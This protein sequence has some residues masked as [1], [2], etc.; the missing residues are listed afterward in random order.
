MKREVQDAP[1]GLPPKLRDKVAIVGFADGHRDA[2][3]ADT[4]EFE[5]WGLNR[6]F[7]VMK[8]P[9][10]AWFDIHDLG[11]TYGDG[12]P[13]GRDEQWIEFARGFAGPVY[14]RG[15]DVGLAQSWG[16]KNA[17][18]YPLDAVLAEFPRYFTNSISY[19]IALSLLVGHTELHVYGVDMAQ[20]SLMNAEYGH[21]RPSCEFFLGAAMGRGVQVVLPVG[22]DLLKSSHLYGVEDDTGFQL[23]NR[24]RMQELGG[25]KEQ[26]KQE[27]ANLDAQIAAIQA[28]KQQVFAGVN[29]LDGAM[30]QVA[31]QMR[32]L[33]PEPSERITNG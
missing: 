30:Q 22:S 27:M 26:M 21:Q 16:V 19:M 6:L 3:P 7:Q 23:K 17:V 11:A 28:K 1:T 33:S 10:T 8:R 12:R 31:Y 2:A 4:S 15:Q 9:W 14:V 13:G 24:A 25:R 32:Q 20:D 29:Q 5:I 18:P